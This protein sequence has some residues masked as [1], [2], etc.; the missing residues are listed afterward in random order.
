LKSADKIP[1]EKRALWAELK[2]G[3]MGGW[4]IKLHD[5]L[6]AIEKG[7]KHLGL[8]DKGRQ[9]ASMPSE[10][11]RNTLKAVRA[12]TMTVDQA[13]LDL[14]MEG[15]SIP[16]SLRILAARQKA[17][18]GPPDDGSYSPVSPEEMASRAARRREQIESQKKTFLPERQADVQ[19]IKEELGQGAFGPEK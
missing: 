17:D 6:A 7:M 8:Y 1:H 11:T 5:K 12:G 18:D 14:D 2:Q 4:S 16:D 3:E 13:I 15:I 9:A 19:A 10:I